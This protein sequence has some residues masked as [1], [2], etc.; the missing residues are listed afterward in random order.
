MDIER[1]ISARSRGV[2]PS[3]IRRVYDLAARLKNPINLTIGQPDFPVPGPVKKAAIAAI[4]SD[5]NGYTPTQ[6]IV[7]LREALARRL[8]QEVGWP[9][10]A[11]LRP[12]ATL[13]DP[14]VMVTSGTAG[15]LWL[16]FVALVGEGDE[17]IFGDPYFVLYPQL[18]NALGA[19]AVICD[20]Y[21]DF[22]LTAER[23][24]PLVTSKTKVVLLNSPGNPSGVVSTRR[25]CEDL[26]DLCRRKN[27]LLITD[28]IYDEFTFEEAREATSSGSRCP[29]PA[30][31][32][33]SHR[34]VLLIRG[35]G[36]TYGPTGWRL[37][38]AAGPRLLL[39]EMTKLQ[40]HMYICAPAPLQYG[41]MAALD[42]DVSDIVRSYQKRRDYVVSR[43]REV[44]EVAMPGG[45]FYVY[46][47]V[48]ERLGMTANQFLDK[49]VE[50]NLLVVPS[51]AFSRRDTHLRIS[52]A[53]DE[54]NLHKGID[55]LVELMRG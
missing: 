54:A 32:P 47:K 48:P 49:C 36:K 42:Y 50:R 46:P 6:G 34:D 10:D 30:R 11:R 14:A 17:A 38:Y 26:L 35:F 20:T 25:E 8:R 18:C 2:E 15:A 52:Y 7:S 24:E 51:S 27:V 55:V 31:A 45:A 12:E 39:E 9:V 16:V 28:E 3:G 23:V 53:T 37:G 41:A 33:G 1:L 13:D 19:R 5:R 44:T 4:E 22:R 21:P 29:S 43:L 40:Q